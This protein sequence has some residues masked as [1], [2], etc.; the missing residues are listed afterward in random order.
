MLNGWLMIVTSFL[1]FGS[2]P[3]FVSAA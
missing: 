3:F 2:I 1:F